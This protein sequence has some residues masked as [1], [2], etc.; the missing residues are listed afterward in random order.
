MSFDS[1]A[2][3]AFSVVTGSPGQAGTE[4][5]VTPG[6]ETR[7]ATPP[8]NMT[9]FPPLQMPTPENSEIVRVTGI[10]GIIFTIVRAQEGTSAQNI[11][12]GWQL[13]AGP[14]DKTFSDLESAISD[15][16]SGVAD[17][18]PISSPSFTGTPTAPTASV[19]DASTKLATTAYADRSA[20]AAVSSEAG[21]TNGLATLTGTTLTA[22]Q[23]P[24]SVVNGTALGLTAVQPTG[25]LPLISTT[26]L[27][28]QNGANGTDDTAVIQTAIDASLTS[29][30]GAILCVDCPVQINGQTTGGGVTW[31]VG[32]AGDNIEVYCTANGKI[33]RTVQ[34]A[35]FFASGAG[36]LAALTSWATGRFT[37]ATAYPITG[38]YAKGSIS[39]TTAT[40]GDAGNF[41]AGDYAYLRTA[42]ITNNA[43]GWPE[44][45]SEL[46]IVLSANASTGVIAFTRPTGKPYQQEYFQPLTV[47]NKALTS[48]VATLTLSVVPYTVGETITVASVDSTFNGTYVITAKTSTTVSYALVAADVTSQAASGTITGRGGLSSTTTTSYPADYVIHKVT[49]RTLKNLKFH[50][51]NFD[52]TATDRNFISFWQVD[53]VEIMH[54]RGT[55]NAGFYTGRDYIK[56]LVDNLNYHARGASAPSMTYWGAQ[57]TGCSDVTWRNIRITGERPAYS[58]IHEGCV[59]PVIRDA[60]ILYVAATLVDPGVDVRARCYDAIF[61]GVKVGGV[62]GYGIFIDAT[63]TGGGTISRCTTFGSPLTAA[64]TLG[65]TTGS[66]N[67]AADNDFQAGSLNLAPSGGSPAVA[68][69]VFSAAISS[70]RLTSSIGHAQDP[71]WM[72]VTIK[73]NVSTAFDNGATLNIGIFGDTG[74]YATGI[75]LT[76]IGQPTIAVGSGANVGH[77]SASRLALVATVINGS[78][79]PTVGHAQIAVETVNVTPLV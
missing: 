63:C 46:F 15:A 28:C 51:L 66:W 77:Y 65:D 1:H 2:N 11:L 67:I 59:R 49:D 53:G 22:A 27:G 31:G 34:G 41:T 20:A 42:Q 48:N 17:A 12:T 57:A 6:Q 37:D 26:A 30:G 54:C 72:L 21:A 23:V 4:L 35:G 8:F 73:V 39:V 29:S 40:A 9:A 45:D 69:K 68:P 43:I 14:T 74:R 44:C 64:V 5:E 33:N 18:A 78:G 38:T 7:F 79:A 75:A 3:F 32:L 10:D 56:C 13:A 60:R 71:P 70:S 36:K 58:H 61:D 50:H 52:T 25:P 62:F 47:T 76:A 55:G 19:G 24:T 16:Q